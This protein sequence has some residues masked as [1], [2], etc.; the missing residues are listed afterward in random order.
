MQNK[1][2]SSS[3]KGILALMLGAIGVVYGDIGTSPLYALESCFTI[4]KIPIIEEN[5][6]G[7]ISL[8][9]WLLFL[10]VYLKYIIIVMRCD[11][12]GEGGA[13]ILSSICKQIS[14][15]YIKKISMFLGILGVSLF[16][17]DSVITPAISVLSACEGLK[18]V[19]NL[20]EHSIINIALLI[21]ILLFKLQSQ[22]SGNIGR[23]FG[24]IMLIWFITLS[25]L[26]INSILKNPAILS[27]FNPYQAIKF[28]MNNKLIGFI[29]LGG[30]ILVVSG[31]E[32]LYAD[33]GHFG[34]TPIRLSWGFVV[35]P[36]L[37]L[38]YLGQGAL[39]LRNPELIDNVF[40]HL[41]PSQLMY[42]MI[43]LSILA[44]II[45]SQA[46]ISGLFSLAQQSIMLNYL[47][48]MT[49]KH[50]SFYQIGQIYLPAIN[51]ILFILTASAVIIFK[52]SSNLSF[53]YGLSVASVMMV[54]TILTCMV[55]YFK[56]KW[57]LLKT[58]IIFMPL[59][60]LDCLFVSS[61]LNKIFEGAWYTIAI[62]VITM[63]I[64]RVWQK[65]NSALKHQR[66][67]S[68]RN[69]HKF[70]EKQ[71]TKYQTRIPGCAVFFTRDINKVPGTLAVNLKHNKYLHEKI[72]FV[73]I[74]T[75]DTARVHNSKR[76]EYQQIFPN[77][78]LITANFGFYEM[79]DLDKVIAWAEEQN[80]LKPKEEISCFLSQGLPVIDNGHYLNK[81]SEKLYIFMSK[82]ALP[83]YEFFKI[84]SSKLIELGVM[85]KV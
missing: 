59:L 32:A 46:V 60:F 42:P 27:A 75:K 38:N 35:F 62:A 76:F 51:Y 24:Y 57:S 65:G 17:G 56:W 4:T 12:H 79:P 23:Y 22:G 28:I 47:P 68:S 44:T 50:T 25:L 7:I 14:G 39:L 45:A 82:N 29:T 80:I 81:F 1:L 84:D 2:E 69:I 19:T 5:I 72:L 37:I 73:S 33:M 20:P 40:Y 77:I 61:N 6:I 8:F 31:V 21:L 30:G 58:A 18:L 3:N 48:R 26:G 83:A 53:A 16:M 70:L 55:A 34:K 85:Y 41:T 63:Y 10:V 54:T 11:Q 64:M 49:I 78:Y 43:I 9:L 71:L 74:I 15:K 36:A 67:D 13:L 52:N 66:T